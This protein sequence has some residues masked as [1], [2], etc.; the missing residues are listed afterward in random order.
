M[1]RRLTILHSGLLIRLGMIS[2]RKR[3]SQEQTHGQESSCVL[4]PL[5]TGF[6]S[7]LYLLQTTI[8]STAAGTVL[9]MPLR[10]ARRRL[11]KSG[12]FCASRSKA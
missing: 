11:G 4:I 9:I 2:T 3:H 8:A 1:L 5:P 7:V 10:L 12:M 6:I